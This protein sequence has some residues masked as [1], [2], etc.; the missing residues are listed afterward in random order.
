MVVSSWS[1]SIKVF[2]N[3]QAFPIVQIFLNIVMVLPH[4][5]GGCKRRTSEWLVIAQQVLIILFPISYLPFISLINI[6]IGMKV[7][8]GL[9]VIPMD[10]IHC[11][12]FSYILLLG[13]SEWIIH[14]LFSWLVPS[15]WVS[16]V[17]KILIFLFDVVIDILLGELFIWRNLVLFFI[18]FMRW[19]RGLKLLFL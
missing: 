16:L 15:A 12:I 8:S 3:F 9:V 11:S 2:P 13:L 4:F 17:I 7:G 10:N 14:R 19:R 18:R 5:S 1:G 6:S